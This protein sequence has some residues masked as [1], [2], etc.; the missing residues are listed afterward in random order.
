[1]ECSRGLEP[2]G[3][4]TSP[5]WTSDGNSDDRATTPSVPS[6]VVEAAIGDEVGGTAGV[7]VRAVEPDERATWN[8]VL[9]TAF[10]RPVRDQAADEDYW[11]RHPGPRG[12]HSEQLGAFVGGRLVGTAHVFSSA[13][14]L[15]GG[16]DLPVEALSGVGVRATHRRR[17][18]LTRV[19]DD[20]LGGAVERG[21]AATVLIASEYPI[22]GRFGY[23]PASASTAW[24]V[25]VPARFRDPSPAGA[26]EVIEGGELRELGPDLFAE[27]RRARPGNVQRGDL[28][29]DDL[30][31]LDPMPWRSPTSR[32]F[33]L[34]RDPDGTAAGRPAGY[35][36]YHVEGRFEG[37][38]P[39]GTAVVDDLVATTPGAAAG[40]WRYVCEIDWVRT[41]HAGDR[42][43]DEVLPLLLVDGRQARRTAHDDLLWLR[44]LD[45]V[46]VLDA[47]RWLDERR[48]VLE[49]VDPAGFA[50]GRF[51]IDGGR[52]HRSHRSPD[53]TVPVE[54]LGALVLGGASVHSL[55]DAGWLQEERSGALDDASVL[56][57]W[58]VAPWC[59]TW[60]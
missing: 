31:G 2:E 29:W 49:V 50:T 33:A 53:L 60:F 24:E 10:L 41:V 17:G 39:A 48:L 43:P 44:V 23:G 28:E 6:T 3:V 4:D 38:R 34:W 27:L 32:T 12:E 55:A 5:S 16:A 46:A 22:Y 59:A 30:S 25:T 42:P 54:A 45:P 7:E 52:C 36:A 47:R 8:A 11:A 20:V 37:R 19:M 1:M 21:L 51:E 26:V 15:P 14:S 56:L 13:L 57:H 9:D 18:V 35:V 58:P 40:L